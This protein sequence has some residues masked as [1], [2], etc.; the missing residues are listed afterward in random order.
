MESLGFFMFNNSTSENELL[1]Y[2]RLALIFHIIQISDHMPKKREKCN[3]KN[4]VAKHMM[5]KNT[6]G[7]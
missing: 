5:K 4:Q 1:R 7:N 2:A 6:Q 3:L